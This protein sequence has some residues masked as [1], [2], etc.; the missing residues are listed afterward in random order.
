MLV[1][2]QCSPSAI[3]G[4][5]S[6]FLSCLIIRA[7]RLLLLRCCYLCEIISKRNVESYSTRCRTNT[8]PWRHGLSALK[9]Q[10]ASWWWN[11]VSS[12]LNGYLPSDISPD[13]K[14]IL[15]LEFKVFK[16]YASP[17]VQFDRV[18]GPSCLPNLS[19][20]YAYFMARTQRWG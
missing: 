10:L 17:L 15:W 4:R 11:Q 19:C 12:H 16:L 1:F 5:N 14:E 2:L 13:S 18:V 8:K 3:F 7:R 6:V 9:I 20:F